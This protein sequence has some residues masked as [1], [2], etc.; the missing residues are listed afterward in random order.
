MRNPAMVV[1]T[2]WVDQGTDEWFPSLARVGIGS[3]VLPPTREV[4]VPWGP[5]SAAA[6]SGLPGGTRTPDLLLRR[7]LLYPVELRAAGAGMARLAGHCNVGR[8]GRI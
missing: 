5:G 2:L 8:S 4:L 6:S 1:T 3:R 7:Q